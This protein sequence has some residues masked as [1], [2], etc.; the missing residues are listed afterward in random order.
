MCSSPDAALE[1]VA[2]VVGVRSTELLIRI[3]S[4][5]CEAVLDTASANGRPF[6]EA[7]A[8][9][10]LGNWPDALPCPDET[11]WF[12]GTRLPRETQFENGLLPL[13]DT[14]PDL[15]GVVSRLAREVGV[16]EQDIDSGQVSGSHS[17]KLVLIDTSGPYG[18][19]LRTTVVHPTG[20]H[21]DFLDA[22]EIVIDLARS[23]AGS[24]A[25]EVLEMYRSQTRSCVVWFLGR[26]S[27]RD[28]I[29]RSLAYIHDA[30]GENDDPGFW[31]TC[32]NG[33]GLR[34]LRSDIVRI[35][36]L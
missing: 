4:C 6:E 31:N 15:T 10:V 34:V 33:G 11:V 35:E 21:R 29:V 27:R 1:S 12:H 20:A 8:W 13:R 24:R 16:S 3:R 17:T 23:I 14:L 26:E 9:D 2:E 19:L 30:M 28:V 32:F 18:S 7:L 36:W 22:P 5:S 25:E